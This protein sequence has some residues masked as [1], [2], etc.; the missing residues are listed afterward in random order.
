MRGTW[1]RIVRGLLLGMFVLLLSGQLFPLSARA[2]EK[3]TIYNSPYVS[4]APDGLAWTTHAGEQSCVQ[5]QDGLTVSTGISSSLR[6]LEE[7]EHYYE[8]ARTGE[9]PVGVW[10]VEHAYAQCIHN[11]YP[12]GQDYHRLQFAKKRCFRRYYS[13]W[14]ATCA[15]CGKQLTTGLTYM[16]KEAAESLDYLTFGTLE[17]YYLCPFCRN[18]EQGVPMI[19]HACKAV[20]WNQYRVRYLAN[21]ADARGYMD[22]SYHMYNNASVYEGME[23]TPITHLSRNTYSRI[24]YVFLGWNTEAD[25]SGISYEEEQEIYNLSKADWQQ[26]GSGEDGTIVLYAQ[27]KR[28]VSTLKLDAAGGTYAGAGVYERAGEYGTDYEVQKNAVVSPKGYTVSFVT[29]GGTSVAPMVGTMAITGWQAVGSLTGI[30]SD[31]TY[32]YFGPDGGVDTLRALY[33]HD[34]I[35]LPT[36]RKENHSF[37]GWYYDS[38]FT[39]PAGGAGDQIVPGGDTT[40]YAQ[41]VELTL[42]SKDN[43]A[44]NGGKG[45]VDLSWVQSDARNKSYLLY[46]KRAGTGWVRIN[47]ASDVS[48]ESSVKKAYVYNGREKTYT[49]P[50]TG[51]YTLTADGAQGGSYAGKQG[52]RGGEVTGTFWLTAGEKLTITVGG[53]NG[54]NGGGAATQY[55]GGGGRTSIVSDQKGILLVAGGG[56]GATPEGDGGK[57]GTG[58]SVRNT[59]DGESGMAGG[60]GGYYGGT[61]GESILHH[62]S[63][64]CIV[65]RTVSATQ[66]SSYSHWT[67]DFTEN[68]YFTSLETS[69]EGATSVLIDAYGKSTYGH[70]NHTRGMEVAMY[71]QTGRCLWTMNDDQVREKMYSLWRTAEPANDLAGKEWY[72]STF[73]ELD[74]GHFEDREWEYDNSTYTWLHRDA[75]G[76]L[77]RYI[78]K[79]IPSRNW[80]PSPAA[81]VV[82]EVTGIRKKGTIYWGSN[83]IFYRESV[84]L[85]S[86]VTS[87]RIVVTKKCDNWGDTRTYATL[88]AKLNG[89]YGCG[90]EEGEQISAKPSYGGSNYVNTGEATHYTTR[91]GV[92]SGNGLAT[93]TSTAIGYQEG[94]EL[95]GV[96]ATDQR[97]PERIDAK[98][99]VVEATEGKQ[100]SV[101]W[102]PPKDLGTTYYHKAESYLTG[103]TSL[104]CTSNVT[105][106]TLISGI[107]GYYFQINE[108]SSTTVTAENGSYT[109]EPKAVLPASAAVQY[110]HVAAVDVAGNLGA[111][112]HIRIEPEKIVW[113]IATKQLVIEEG[114]N[115]CK[116][117]AQNTWYVRA[118]GRTPFTLTHSSYMEGSASDNYQLT[119]V[120]FETLSSGESA[121]SLLRLP[122]AAGDLLQTT[123]LSDEISYESEGATLLSRYPYTKARRSAKG[124]ALSCIQCFTVDAAHSGAQIRVMPRVGAT[125]KSSGQLQRSN[126]SEDLKNSITLTPDGEAPVITGF[127][128]L[129]Q[130]QLIDRRNG[131]IWLT[132]GASDALSGLAD[133]HVSIVNTDNYVEQTYTA[134]EAGLIQI[135]ITQDDPIFAGD[136]TATATATDRV[137]NTV[138]LGAV[139]TE[140]S[141]ETEVTRVLAPHDPIFKCGESGVLTVKVWGYA[142]RI[143]VAFPDALS[144]QNPELNLI[145]D[146]TENP[147]YLKEVEI[148]FMVPLY[149]QPGENLQIVVRAYKGDKQLEDYP[150]ISVIAV[151]GTLLDELRTRLR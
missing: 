6:A 134:D 147:E 126:R 20:S 146:C 150:S 120:L 46:Q 105:E 5:Y 104:L 68:V 99:A 79:G 53:R 43:Y 83:E 121:S 115:V 30:Y 15:D 119:D 110:L 4:F 97:A 59:S 91:N 77:W 128:R 23:V 54:Y 35:V 125:Q 75:T 3:Q 127:E 63:E 27:W 10:R 129:E 33:T 24:G 151:E 56:G 109:R 136:F 86:T 58:E 1:N 42:V 72:G 130:L 51:L 135:H 84:S 29:N 78:Q 2:W 145:L 96:K 76:K 12:S 34:P 36:T 124:T 38:A 88:S 57:G 62:H 67:D 8:T 108:Q 60:G 80:T 90:Y 142:D 144:V 44:A 87:I 11:T 64:E 32:T 113:R 111:T 107:A 131:E 148:P 98:T 73:T 114:A 70:N 69:T 139:A 94:H 133:F 117:S 101:S 18:L 40:L 52:G 41:W 28:C 149:T 65:E 81:N 7:G 26:K 61:A 16:S 93:I 71:D 89:A 37:G 118:D 103:S 14:Q 49:I 92:R 102:Q 17:Y 55:G 31:G 13:G 137:G 74:E 19:T 138:T 45:A 122:F 141:L 22:D 123:V 85:P 112:A 132:L 47:N 48:S 21:A 9:I 100:V 116:A 143:E 82:G 39:K 106:N 50:Y 95:L 25:G 66:T 140:F